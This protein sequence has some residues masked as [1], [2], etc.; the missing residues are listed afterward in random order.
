[1][2]QKNIFPAETIEFSNEYHQTVNT[3][4]SQI[5]YIVIVLSVIAGIISLPF[6]YIDVTIQADG[7]I[8]PVNEK[9]EVI[10]VQSGIVENI[11]VKESKK[12]N[13]GDTILSIISSE[14]NSKAEFANYQIV[15]DSNFIADIK[16]LLKN[17]NSKNLKTAYYIQKNVEY[18]QK[19]REIKNKLLRAKIELDRNIPLY[20]KGVISVQEFDNLTLTYNAVRDEIWTFKESYKNLLQGDLIQKQNDLKNYNTQLKQF[21]QQKKYFIIKAPV[22]GTIEQFSGIYTGTNLQAGQTIA[23]ISPASEI[24]A[25][26]Y[27]SPKNIGYIKKGSKANVQVTAFN[28]NDWGMLKA[29]VTE[30]SND[31]ISINNKPVFRVRCK[32]NKNYLQLKSGFKGKL[33]KGMTVRSRFIVT[34]RSLWQLLFDNINDWMNPAMNE[35]ND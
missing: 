29:E 30:I 27:I 13:K 15:Q 32:L 8:R 24:T 16:E 9:T 20:N 6:I 7:L 35:I 11:Y 5:I 2:S 10:S 26:I 3:V 23:I 17:R 34:K 1:M 21:E 33:K 18:K 28:Y 19:L 14:I 12:I 4:K 31:F 25:E 22:S